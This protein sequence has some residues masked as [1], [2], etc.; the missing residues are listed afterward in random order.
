MQDA[1]TDTGRGTTAGREYGNNDDQWEPFCTAT[2]D[3]RE[4]SVGRTHRTGNIEADYQYCICVIPQCSYKLGCDYATKYRQLQRATVCNHHGQN[5]RSRVLSR[6]TINN[7][8]DNYDNNRHRTSCIKHKTI[9][10]DSCQW[11]VHEGRSRRDHR[12]PHDV[13]RP[14]S[15]ASA[16]HTHMHARTRTH[17]S[18][19]TKRPDQTPKTHQDRTV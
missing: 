10:T 18:T 2:D 11:S 3:K 12:W 9:D 17:R 6:S 14:S 4:L 1:M 7:T 15:T 16:T 8:T 5:R 19:T 13:R